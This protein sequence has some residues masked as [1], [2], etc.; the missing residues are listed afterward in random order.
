MTVKLHTTQKIKSIQFKYPDGAG[1]RLLAPGG[2]Q[3]DSKRFVSRH[4]A[5]RGE[6]DGRQEAPPLQIGGAAGPPKTIFSLFLTKTT[7]HPFFT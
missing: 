3:E 5:S 4:A 7:R 2:E 6:E 1:G